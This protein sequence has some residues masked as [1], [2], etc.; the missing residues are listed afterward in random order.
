MILA[1]NARH[2]LQDALRIDQGKF[3]GIFF[4]FHLAKGY[5]KVQG[6][7]ILCVNVD[8]K[9]TLYHL[10]LYHQDQYICSKSKSP[11]QLLV[12]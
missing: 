12:V 10:D 9:V 3:H 7:Y 4:T 2:S 1:V 11:L 6:R 8:C 5:I